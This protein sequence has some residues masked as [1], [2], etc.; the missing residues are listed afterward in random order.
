MTLSDDID[1]DEMDV[2]IRASERQR[3]ADE[4][5]AIADRLKGERDRM[6]QK[7]TRGIQREESR[8]RAVAEWLEQHE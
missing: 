3:L 5:R 8:W 1:M 2:K 4:A 7:L 6:N